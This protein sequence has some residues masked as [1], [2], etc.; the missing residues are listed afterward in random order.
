MVTGGV[1][2]RFNYTGTSDDLQPMVVNEGNTVVLD[3]EPYA[4]LEGFVRDIRYGWL[5][6]RDAVGR[7]A[8]LTIDIAE[9][10]SEHTYQCLIRGVIS[11][12]PVTRR[13]SRNLV[14]RGLLLETCISVYHIT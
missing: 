6:G 7:M 13:Q 5:V 3:C 4:E 11:K 9:I 2:R 1:V 10:S 12:N 14:V 8:M